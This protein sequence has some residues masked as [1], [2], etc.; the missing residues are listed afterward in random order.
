MAFTS[1][2]HHIPG[3]TQD[4]TDDNQRNVVQCG[5]PQWCRECQMEAGILRDQEYPWMSKADVEE[6]MKAP[7][8]LWKPVNKI[9]SLTIGVHSIGEL[10]DFLKQFYDIQLDAAGS[11]LYTSIF[12]NDVSEDEDDG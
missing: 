9:I 6:S 1:H 4:D 2:G 8:E 12:V 5:G 10:R 7:D 3:T 11:G